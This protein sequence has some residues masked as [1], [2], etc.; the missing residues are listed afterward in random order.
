ML[1]ML[2]TK[3]LVRLKKGTLKDLIIEFSST[4]ASSKRKISPK[5][6][7]PSNIA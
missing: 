3:P 1:S 2:S 5:D 4:Y 7:R 6:D